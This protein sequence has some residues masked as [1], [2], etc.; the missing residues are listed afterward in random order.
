MS[1]RDRDE[2]S[3]SNSRSN[4]F[5]RILSELQGL[6]FRRESSQ[7]AQSVAFGSAP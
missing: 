7:Q 4:G 3:R 6:P 1:G 5:D 2:L